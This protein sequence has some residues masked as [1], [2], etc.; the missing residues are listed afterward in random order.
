MHSV[1]APEADVIIHDAIYGCFRPG[2]FIPLLMTRRITRETTPNRGRCPKL[3]MVLSIREEDSPKSKKSRKDTM[4]IVARISMRSWKRKL[5]M[6][7]ALLHVL[8][9]GNGNR[10]MTLITD[11]NML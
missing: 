8:V 3:T 2:T 11:I 5:F 4:I 10:N 1:S 9:T 7:T 6:I